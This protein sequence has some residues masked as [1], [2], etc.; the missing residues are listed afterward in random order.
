MRI[1]FRESRFIT[2]HPSIGGGQSADVIDWPDA[3]AALGV[4]LPGSGGEQR[5][6]KITASLTGSSPVDTHHRPQL[7]QRQPLV[8]RDIGQAAERLS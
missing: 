7:S 4:S 6:L 2:V 8:V 3:V 1:E 5:M